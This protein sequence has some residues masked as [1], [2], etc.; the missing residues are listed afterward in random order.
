MMKQSAMLQLGKVIA[1]DLARGS[2]GPGVRDLGEALVSHPDSANGGVAGAP[3][4]RSIPLGDGA[5][6]SHP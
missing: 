4:H 6:I 2:P 3:N 5:Q 1:K